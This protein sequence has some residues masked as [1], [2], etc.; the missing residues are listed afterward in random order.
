MNFG[1]ILPFAIGVAISPVPIIAVILML[2]SDKAKSNGLA[3]LIGWIGGLLIAGGI[4]LTLANAG[5]I[6]GGGTPSTISFVI[7]LL[8]GLLLLFLAYRNWQ[9]RPKEDEEPEMPKWMAGI[10]SFTPARRWVL[11]RSWRG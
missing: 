5:K 11:G 2:F 4:V 9:T 3:F 6:S 10:D 8:L 7:Q 1:D